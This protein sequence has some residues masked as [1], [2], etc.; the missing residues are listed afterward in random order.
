MSNQV[1]DQLLDS[2]LDRYEPA[3]LICRKCGKT[4]AFHPVFEEDKANL[5]CKC[6]NLYE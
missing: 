5:Q 3:L 6:G 1:N 2:L 4:G